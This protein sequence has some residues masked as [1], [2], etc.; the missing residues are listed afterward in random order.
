M[1]QVL[2]A[3]PV[4]YTN[5]YATETVSYNSKLEAKCILKWYSENPDAWSIS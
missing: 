5:S 2:D 3:L 4:D 1:T